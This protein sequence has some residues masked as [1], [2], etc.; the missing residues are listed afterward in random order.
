[1]SACPQCGSPGAFK[2]RRREVDGSVED[3]VRCAAC[4]YEVVLRSGPRE[5]VDLE[6]DVERLR[7]RVTAGEGHLAPVLALREA[8]LETARA[9]ARPIEQ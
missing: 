1:M 6:V 4:P 7:G 5:L 2:S 8:R 3:Y 9:S